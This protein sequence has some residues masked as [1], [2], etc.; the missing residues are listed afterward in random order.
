MWAAASEYT[1]QSPKSNT[2]WLNAGIRPVNY[3]GKMAGIRVNEN[4]HIRN[5]RMGQDPRHLVDKLVQIP[6]DPFDD[7]RESTWQD[8]RQ[9][10]ELGFIDKSF[11]LPGNLRR[12]PSRCE[13][14]VMN[15]SHSCNN[16]I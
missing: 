8:A 1:F 4:V 11:L 9:L 14:P 3:A 2:E 15:L 5:I 7:P 13:E 6:I 10:H 16:T 12:F